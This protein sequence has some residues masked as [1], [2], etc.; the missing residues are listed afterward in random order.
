MLT[1]RREPEHKN[2]RA[3]WTVVLA[4]EVFDRPSDVLLDFG[5]SARVGLHMHG[6]VVV[7]HSLD[8]STSGV[9]IQ[10]GLVPVAV[11]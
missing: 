5:A 6:D 1:L 4:D 11:A 10:R 3:S 9:A 7:A 8:E 2:A